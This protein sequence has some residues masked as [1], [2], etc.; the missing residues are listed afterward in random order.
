MAAPIEIK[1]TEWL[2]KAWEQ[3]CE[4]MGGYIVATL[5]FLIVETVLF[6][7]CGIPVLILGP[8]VYAGFIL[9]CR[10]IRQGE[11]TGIGEMF[12]PCKTHLVETMIP[13]LCI[14][15]GAAVVNLVVMGILNLIPIL[16]QLVS[17]AFCAWFIGLISI[18]M[19][20]ILVPVMDENKKGMDALSASF[21]LVMKEPV[22]FSIFGL[23]LG[24]ISLVGSACCIGSLFTTPVILLANLI[25]YETIMG[26]GGDS[27][28]VSATDESENEVTDSSGD[29]GG[30]ENKAE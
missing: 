14:T 10:K 19:V 13:I 9:H 22:Q 28:G 24:A 30:D 1:H 16:G 11:E 17:V 25:A 21:E 15:I 12:D 20:F 6:L 26:G 4:N 18:L 29:E 8:A 27:S 2:K 3:F 7:L 5:V 23:L